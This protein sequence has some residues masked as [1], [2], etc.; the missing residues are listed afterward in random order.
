VPL[1]EQGSASFYIDT[2][3]TGLPK[4]LYEH[5]LIY[6]FLMVVILPVNKTKILTSGKGQQ[7]ALL[8]P[9]KNFAAGINGHCRPGRTTN[10]T[11]PPQARR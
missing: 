8:Y 10:A 9:I 6:G 5:P 1:L 11:A 4:R 7:P 3:G 2:D